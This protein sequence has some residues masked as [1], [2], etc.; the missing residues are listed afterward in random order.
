MMLPLLEKRTVRLW[1]EE[2]LE[3]GVILRLRQGVVGIVQERFPII[4]DLAQQQIEHIHNPVLL[5][6]LNIKVAAAQNVEEA[7][8]YLREAEKDT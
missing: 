4:V 3:Y 7:E 5:R 2:G 8:R 1:V 6:R